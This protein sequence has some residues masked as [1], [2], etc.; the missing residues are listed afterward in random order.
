MHW[1]AGYL[2]LPPKPRGRDRKGVDCWGLPRLV[3]SEAA[4]VPEHELADR[5]ADYLGFDDVQAIGECMGAFRLT[6]WRPIPSGSERPFDIIAFDCDGD[7][8]DD[9]LGLVV[10]PGAML[11]VEQ[12]SRSC[13]ESYRIGVRG[14][15]WRRH[16][17]GFYRHERLV[18]RG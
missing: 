2:G 14:R 5:A 4:G 7:G 1:S 8:A 12:D 11:H 10:E 16:I 6:P 3:L 17:S 15:Y 9:H 13:V 18:E